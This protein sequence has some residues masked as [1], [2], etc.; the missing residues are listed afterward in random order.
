MTINLWTLLSFTLAASITPG[1][2]NVMLTASG[3]NFG[4]IRTLPHIVGIAVGFGSLILLVGL[5]LGSLFQAYP[6]LHEILRYVGG[7]YLL[8]LAW[9]IVGATLAAESGKARPLTLLEAAGFQF[10]NPKAW[11]MAVTAITTFSTP[12]GLYLL[13]TL[14]VTATFLLV[15]VFSTAIWTLSGQVIGRF[16]T[17]GRIR[18]AFNLLMAAL[19]V[20]SVAVLFLADLS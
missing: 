1:P 10:A 3:A 4:Y 15:S 20:L 11:I 12:G 9:R 7:L 17:S 13:E 8:Y 14:V 2:N 5:G 19:L 16:L 6:A 18:L